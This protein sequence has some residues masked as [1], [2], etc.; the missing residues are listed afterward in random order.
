MRAVAAAGRQARKLP[1]SG[2]PGKPSFH[3]PP[4]GT[5]RPQRRQ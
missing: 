3:L 4:A 5:M 2:D 1:F